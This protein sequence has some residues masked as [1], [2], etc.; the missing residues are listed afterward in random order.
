MADQVAQPESANPAPGDLET[1][2]QFVNTLDVEKPEAETFAQPADLAKWLRQHG[3]TRGVVDA[4]AADLR[5]ARELRAA[6][7]QLLLANNG[8]ERD[9]HDATDVLNRAA[10]RA[11]VGVAFSPEGECQIA[12]AGG[13]V[14]EGI[15]NLLAIVAQAMSDGEWRRLKVCALD[16]CQWAFYDKSKNRSGHW[17]S[18]AECG[19]RAKARTFR[20]RRRASTKTR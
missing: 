12:P 20:E 18:M 8:I 10:A 14:D 4:K 11:K 9:V 6:L 15:G 19:N 1:V 17:C 16:T 13:G 3:L 7:H 5:R 2:R